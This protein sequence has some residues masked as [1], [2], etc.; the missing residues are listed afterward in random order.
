MKHDNQLR[1]NT[2]DLHQIPKY[3]LLILKYFIK[4]NC[5]YT[6]TGFVWQSGKICRNLAQ[7]YDFAR[8]QEL[9]ALSGFLKKLT[10]VDFRKIQIFDWTFRSKD[11]E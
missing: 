3:C 2:L 7:F 11:T 10:I 1:H 6:A 9:K 5:P 4:N 8:V